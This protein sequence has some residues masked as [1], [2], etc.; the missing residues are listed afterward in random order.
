MAFVTLCFIQL[1]LEFLHW[2][3]NPSL[4]V[5]VLVVLLLCLFCAY[6]FGQFGFYNVQALQILYSSY[7]FRIFQGIHKLTDNITFFTTSVCYHLLFF[8][9]IF[10]SPRFMNLM[11]FNLSL[12]HR[13]VHNWSSPWN[14]TIFSSINNVSIIKSFI[15]VS[16]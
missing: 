9:V 3:T 12:N 2:K 7:E 15:T 5:F 14:N 13:N 8:M 4:H 10:F 11:T 16:P 6:F 1:G